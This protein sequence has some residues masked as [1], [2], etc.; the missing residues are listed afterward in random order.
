MLHLLS[1]TQPNKHVFALHLHP[2]RPFRRRNETI[3]GTPEYDDRA[4]RIQDSSETKSQRT[5]LPARV[6]QWNTCTNSSE[7]NRLSK[8]YGDINLI[9]SV[10]TGTPAPDISEYEA[11]LLEMF[12]ET[13]EA[14]EKV[15]DPGRINSL[16]VNFKLFK[17]LQRIGYPVQ[18]GR[19]LYSQNRCKMDANTKI[20]GTK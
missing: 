13:E 3:P 7:S 18:T 6:R 15:K 1:E 8:H 10:I 9:Y 11:E 4:E 2:K 5:G 19:F 17:L 12:D 16:N 20:N 14:Y